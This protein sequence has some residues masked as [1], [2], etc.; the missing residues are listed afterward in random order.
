LL[1]GAA[2]R[3][4]PVVI[5]FLAQKEKTVI[6][7]FVPLLFSCALTT[8]V[9]AALAGTR[10]SGAEFV[11]TRFVPIPKSMRRTNHE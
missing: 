11:I 3:V 7:R 9:A 10:S 5:A 2:G 6:D 1:S 4:A 8:A